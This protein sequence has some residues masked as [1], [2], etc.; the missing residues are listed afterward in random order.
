[1]AAASAP[2]RA[3]KG[4]CPY[5]DG[6]VGQGLGTA[7]MVFRSSPREP[8]MEPHPWRRGPVEEAG[9]LRRRGWD[10]P[11]TTAPFL[12]SQ[13]PL[14]PSL[15][16][17]PVPDVRHVA[18]GIWPERSTGERWGK[19]PS[20]ER[21]TEESASAWLPAMLAPVWRTR[22]GGHGKEAFLKYRTVKWHFHLLEVGAFP[23]SFWPASRLRKKKALLV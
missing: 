1:M 23:P 12:I 2:S 21:K 5:G 11:K 13:E 19:A 17:V 6:G 18:P 22:E 10:R 7:G 15:P 20:L 3:G 8:E 16:S 4:P 9:H 14:P